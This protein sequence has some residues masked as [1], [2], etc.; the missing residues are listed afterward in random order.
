[1]SFE[2]GNWY[3]EDKPKNDNDAK[4]LYQC[5][6]VD[7]N[8]SVLRRFFDGADLGTFSTPADTKKYSFSDRNSLN[9][10]IDF[11]KKD[12][13]DA[14]CKIT[15]LLLDIRHNIDT[16]EDMDSYLTKWESTEGYTPSDEA[17]L[18]DKCYIDMKESINEFQ[19]LDQITGF[20]KS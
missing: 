17:I 2:V 7:K 10:T 19:T 4:Y 8:V 5:K 18:S 13:F 6:Y 12:K 14:I 16:I 1:M 20:F 11:Y 3:K 9:Q 15:D